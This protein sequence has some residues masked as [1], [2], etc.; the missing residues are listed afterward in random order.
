MCVCVCERERERERQRERE[1]ERERERGK[2][3]ALREAQRGLTGGGWLKRWLVGLRGS[4]LLE[5]EITS[6][7]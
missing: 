4:F 3:E 7:C 5:C 2:K 6:S 1:R